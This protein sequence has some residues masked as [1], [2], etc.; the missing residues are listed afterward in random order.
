MGAYLSRSDLEDLERGLYANNS[1]SRKEIYCIYIIFPII[2]LMFY[3]YIFI[4]NIQFT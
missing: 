3:L 1:R 4:Q 2:L